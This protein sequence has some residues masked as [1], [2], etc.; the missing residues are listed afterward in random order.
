MLN[1]TEDPVCLKENIPIERLYRN[2]NIVSLIANRGGHIEY[3][4]GS[5]EEW[6][7]FKLALIY[8]TIFEEN[9]SFGQ[10]NKEINE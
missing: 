3:L 2:E 1:N 6:F 4:T 5:N 10:K 8:F 7:G 9:H